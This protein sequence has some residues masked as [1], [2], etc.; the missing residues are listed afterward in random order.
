MPTRQGKVALVAT[1][2]ATNLVKHGGGG[3]LVVA[4]TD[5]MTSPGSGA[6]RDR[7]GPGHGG[8]RADACD[9]GYSTSGSP[10]TGLGAIARA[11]EVFDVYS[12]PAEGTVVFA[13][14]AGRP[15]RRAGATAGSGRGVGAMSG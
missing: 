1:E 4:G 12:R 8:R 10:G 3:E 5:E 14:V 15:A 6:A 9:D 2:L 13:R 11:S 7:P